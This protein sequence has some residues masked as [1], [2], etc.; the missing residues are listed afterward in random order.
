[1]HQKKKS[2]LYKKGRWASQLLHDHIT[3]SPLRSAEK[4]LYRPK[5]HKKYETKWK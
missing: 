4:Y 1:M 5:E 3:E 2:Y